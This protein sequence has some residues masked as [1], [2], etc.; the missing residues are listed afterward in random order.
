MKTGQVFKTWTSRNAQ[1]HAS[2]I[3]SIPLLTQTCRISQTVFSFQHSALIG[4]KAV[5]RQTG[6]HD[7]RQQNPL[8]RSTNGV[9]IRTLTSVNFQQ[10]PRNPTPYKERI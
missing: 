9:Q 5:D 6:Y 1:K 2:Y 3:M 4:F 8:Q 10:A 7:N